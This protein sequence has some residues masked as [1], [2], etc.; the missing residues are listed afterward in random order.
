[1]EHITLAEQGPVLV[2]TL[3]RAAKYNALSLTMHAEIG[4]ALARLNRD[5]EL[6]VAVLCAQ[7]KHFTAGVELDQW[8]PVFGS[9][10]GMPEIP[11]GI[12]PFG[13]R[14]ERHAKPLVIAVQGYCFTWGVEI[15]LNTEIRIAASDTQFQMLE[16][17]R[18]L[19]PCCGATFR[20]PREIGWGNAHKVLLTGERWSADDALRWGMVQEVVAPGEQVARAM[21]YARRIA[22]CAPLGVQGALRSSRT[23][24]TEGHDAAV[25]EMYRHLVPVMSSADAAE[26]VRSFIERRKAVFTGR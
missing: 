18:G 19:Y 24:Q 9:G 8:A 7:G 21:D 22:D 26:G 5:P 11:G 1:M 10:A 12:D 14:G 2:I 16:V 15:L 13:M 20:L 3:N 25:A 6:R 17:Q 23:A 4:Q